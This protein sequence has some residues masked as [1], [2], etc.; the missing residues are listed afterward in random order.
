MTN[1]AINRL[2]VKSIPA[3]SAGQ[4][5]DGGGLFLRKS[6]HGAT[7]WVL[8]VSLAGKPKQIGLGSYPDVSLAEARQERDKWKSV[9]KSGKDPVLFR[10]M[11][12]AEEQKELEVKLTSLEEVSKDAYETR[13][14]ELKG[15]ANARRW[16]GALNNHVIPALG[17]QPIESINQIHIRDTL[18]PIWK[19]KPEAARKAINRMN[20]VMLHG[21]ALGL[22]VDLNAIAKAKALLGKQN[23]TANHHPSMPWH[24]VPDYYAELPEETPTQV[25]LKL[26]ILNPGP[27]SKPIRFLHREHLSGNTWTIPGELMKGIKGKTKDWRTPLSEESMR[28]IELTRDFEVR[29]NLFPSVTGKTVISDASMSRQM[30]RQEIPYRPHGFRHAFKTWTA[31]TRQSFMISELCLAHTFTVNSQANYLLTDYLDERREMMDRWSSFVI[32]DASF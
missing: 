31:E 24:E 26:L 28:L 7:R 29:G 15:E 12:R 1:R 16:Y 22:D 20:I 4:H 9:A 27:R 23:H 2:T 11:E 13:K 30:E 19:T 32:G 21:A 25:A 14:A 6:N 5:P 17:N 8:R 18:R 10:K 3:L